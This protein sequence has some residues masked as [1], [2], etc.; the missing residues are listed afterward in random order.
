MR[1]T[2]SSLLDE[3]ERLANPVDDD[4][5]DEVGDG[6][7][8][9]T[10]AEAPARPVTGNPRSFRVLVRN[11]L[12]R[13]VELAARENYDALEALDKASGWDGDAW[14]DALDPMFDLHGNDAIGVDAAARSS[15]LVQIVENGVR[16]DGERV[17][18]GTWFVRQVLDDPAGDHDWAIS[19]VVDLA[20]SD[21]AGAV[22][23]RVVAVGTI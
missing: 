3:W 18:P 16:P 6:P 17:E 1:G 22:V 10:G 21:E 9:G 15:A 8:S 13:R 7:L 12:F 23:L 11:A 20:A 2:D 4:A 14:A 5:D 19:A